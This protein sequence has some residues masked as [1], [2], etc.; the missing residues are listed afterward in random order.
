MASSSNRCSWVSAHPSDAIVSQLMFS[1]WPIQ[2]FCA[3]L[4]TMHARRLC[5]DARIGWTRTLLTEYDAT[6]IVLT[7]RGS[8][9]VGRV[10]VA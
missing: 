10:V 3:M 4:C 2:R 7:V 9:S 6:A 5:G 8:R 1:C